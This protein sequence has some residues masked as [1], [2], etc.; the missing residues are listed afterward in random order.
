M[1]RVAR[2]INNKR[3]NNKEKEQIRGKICKRKNL[4]KQRKKS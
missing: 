4:T 3:D 2:K 1:K